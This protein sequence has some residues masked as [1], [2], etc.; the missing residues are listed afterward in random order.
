MCPAPAVLWGGM[1]NRGEEGREETRGEQVKREEGGAAASA[2]SGERV[3][4][5]DPRHGVLGE[6]DPSTPRPSAA[7]H[8]LPPSRSPVRVAPSHT[9]SGASA[10]LSRFRLIRFDQAG[11]SPILSAPVCSG[12]IVSGWSS[13]RR[14][15]A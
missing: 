15:R 2:K 14:G 8:A 7:S 4:N 9:V 11:F 12:L 10:R 3:L 1:R 13:L 6:S 5:A